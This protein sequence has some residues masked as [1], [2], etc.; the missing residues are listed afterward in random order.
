MKWVLRI[1]GAAVALPVVAIAAI[2]IAYRQPDVPVEA[3]KARWAP[4]P[5]QFMD[6]A[7][8]SVHYRDEGP[9]DSAQ[10]V[11]LI[12][13]TSSSLHTWEAWTHALSFHHRTVSFDLPGFG[14]TGPTPDGNYTIEAY[15]KFVVAMLDKLGIAHATLAGNSLGGE[16]AWG[17]A[18]LY[19]DRVDHL[20][21]VD[22][23]GYAF[24]P[25]SIP[26]GFRIARTP[27]LN[28]LMKDVLPRNVIRDSV[29][30]VY[31]DPS[32][33][34]PELVDRYFQLTTRAGN[35]AAL[36]ERFAQMAPGSMASRIPEI[37]VPTLIE[38]GMRDNLIPP[39]NAEKFH[40]DIAGSRLV[41]YDD[42]GHVP[43]EEDG[44]RTVNA[45]EAFLEQT[46]APN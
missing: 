26:L 29:L 22:S 42:L 40:H 32:K 8:M 41:T 15:A 44:A 12:H 13:G 35:R 45:V 14:L 7:G 46:A 6:V 28:V 38:W 43:Q 19:P 31:G 17:T 11:V 1:A 25:K 9:R 27:V 21:L 24:T 33:V 5:S 2:V 36:R 10:T 30:N 18:V 4:A 34:T 23:A 37:K 39:E 20:V 16:I 3:L